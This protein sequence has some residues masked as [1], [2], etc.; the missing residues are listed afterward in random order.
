METILIVDDEK[1]YPRI[2]SAILEE[3]NYETLSC[4]SGEEA[5][6]LLTESE[7]DLVLTDMR[8]PGMDGISL[9]RAIKNKQPDLPVIM[10]TAHGTVEKAV[11]AMQQGA[12]T[13]ILK[14]FENETLIQH[15]G[16]AMDLYRVVR[17]NR[18]L[19]AMIADRFS[20]SSII[21]KSEAMQQ[22]Y[23]TIRKVAPST[24]TILIEGESGTGKE[25]VARALHFNSPR[26]EKPFIA[27]NCTALAESLL[28]S[29]LFG[30]EKG[31]FTGAISMRKGRFEL[32]DGGTL[33]LDEIGE[34]SPQMQVKLLRVLQEKTIERVGGGKTI[35]VDFRLMAAT[36]KKLH[37]E[38]RKERFRED[39][40]YRLHVVHFKI[41]PLRERDNDILLLA[42]AFLQKFS[43]Q[44]T[45]GQ[46]LSGLSSPCRKHLLDYAWPGNVRQ[47]ENVMER[48]V[49]LAP[50][51]MIT[52]EDL[53]KEI[54][55]QN[56]L[57]PA[58][59]LALPEA[60]LSDSL[61]HVEKE[62]IERAL[63]ASDHIQAHAAARLGITKSG[64]HQKI[65]KYNIRVGSSRDKAD[66]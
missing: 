59:P 7:I 22:I 10:M 51:P 28:E 58:I 1:N 63:K 4:H 26:K 23:A 2:L 39:L 44:R 8:M 30:H 32:A 20:F 27:V 14:P 35:S 21:G 62:L 16:K 34:L 36:N 56:T 12:Y 19:R 13:Y 40:Y 55:E 43:P 25:L 65:K 6:T 50:G 53:P 5:L 11:E 42:E 29:E 66:S 61:A 46:P 31:A 45:D 18:Q 47:L 60:S 37:E 9:L 41:P 49:L 24:A 38:V 15:V 3:E 17:E 33:F 52:P 64:L 54:R 57:S 48:A